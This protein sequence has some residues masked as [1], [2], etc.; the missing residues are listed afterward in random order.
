MSGSI[1]VEIGLGAFLLFNPFYHFLELIRA[2][3]LGNAIAPLSWVV[4]LSITAFGFWLAKAMY[5]R[6]GR[7]VPLWV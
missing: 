6:Y 4:V 7:R 5:K 3:L 2:P 1:S